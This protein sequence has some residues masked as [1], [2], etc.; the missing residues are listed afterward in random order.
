[1]KYV[2]VLGRLAGLSLAEVE[3][4]FGGTKKLGEKLVVFFAEERPD[5]RRLGGVLKIGEKM[6]E[7]IVDFLAGVETGRIVLG[8]SDYTENA[9]PREVLARALTW[10]KALKKYGKSVRIV[11]TGKDAVLSTATVHHNQLGEKKGHIEIILY[12]KQVFLGLGAQNITAYAKR[13]QK[14]PA[15]DAKNGM[16]P[17]K[18]AQILLNLAGKLPKNARI[19]DPFCGSGVVLQ[20]ACLMGYR[21]YG[22]DINAKMVDFSRKNLIWLE[23]EYLA[24]R[25]GK[26]KSEN[27]NKKSEAG[28]KTEYLVEE[29]DARTFQWR[30]EIDAAVAEGYLGPPMTQ[31]PTEIRLKAVKEE[32]RELMLA[33]LENLAGQLDSGVPVVLAVPAWRRADGGYQG[34]N[35]L[36]GVEK[37]GY[38][39]V[40]YQN[41][42][43]A[44]LLYYREGQVVAREI[45]LLRKK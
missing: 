25:G 29:G 28:R 43:R 38:N 23:Q 41:L 22:T 17:P 30:G 42:R 27:N 33:V 20:E 1:M 16:L 36:D 34:L 13:D 4:Q 24:N 15:R 37:M 10:K 39:V 26:D 18:L 44:D 2:A 7:R 12:K 5:L 11:N 3:A 45:I 35:L 21:A 32:C 14:R 31:I 6:T 19:L 8:V 40:K 9:K